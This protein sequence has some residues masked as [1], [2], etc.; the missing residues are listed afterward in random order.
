M[1]KVE[2]MTILENRLI[3]KDTYELKVT[4]ALM[5]EMRTPGQFLHIAI[6]DGWEHVLRRPLSIANVDH[7]IVTIVYK[8]LGK[9]TAKLATKR[10]GDQLDV[11]GP[12]GNGFPVENIHDCNIL[13]IGGGVGIPPLHY[14]GKQLLTQGNQIFSLLGFQTKEQVFYEREFGRLGEVMVTTDD[15]SYGK[16]GRVTDHVAQFKG[17]DLTFSCGPKPML[18]AVSDLPLPGYVSLEERMGCGIGACFACVCEANDERGYVKV[19]ADGP[20]FRKG[21]VVL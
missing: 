16:K 4:G 18:K 6:G 2:Q 21:E 9:G 7:H 13:L 1:Q 17:I 20:V 19:C 15:G 5:N 3:A 10:Q 8:V 12:R 11:L 14:L